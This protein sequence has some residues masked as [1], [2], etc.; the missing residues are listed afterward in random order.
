MRKADLTSGPCLALGSRLPVV[1]GAESRSRLAAREGDGPEPLSPTSKGKRKGGGGGGKATEHDGDGRRVDRRGVPTGSGASLASCLG[2]ESGV[3][4]V[5]NAVATALAGDR[6][7][8]PASS[9]PPSLKED[10]SK[11]YR[12]QQLTLLNFASKLCAQLTNNNWAGCPPSSP[13]DVVDETDVTHPT[14]LGSGTTS[15]GS[16]TDAQII[17][18]CKLIRRVDAV[19]EGLCRGGRQTTCSVC[20]TTTSKTKTSYVCVGTHC[21]TVGVCP[22]TKRLPRG[23]SSR[24]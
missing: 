8:V 5:A 17:R 9:G 18:P 12:R 23:G 7:V 3:G 16:G 6:P 22:A 15:L 20:Q 2:A 13:N 10:A 1:S 11:Q 21:N 24:C 19:K 4:S 14:S